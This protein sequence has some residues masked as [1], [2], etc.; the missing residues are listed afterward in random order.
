MSYKVS[1]FTSYLYFKII[2]SEDG[3][4]HLWEISSSEEV[5]V[6]EGHAKAC[7]FVKFS[8]KHILFASGCKNLVLW[9]PRTLVPV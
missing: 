7:Q 1:S 3:K 9:L 2:G 6:Y 4:V 5:A 8:P